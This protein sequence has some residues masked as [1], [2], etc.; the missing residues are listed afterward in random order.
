MTNQIEDFDRAIPNPLALKLRHY[1]HRFDVFG[2]ASVHLTNGDLHRLYWVHKGP[3]NHI[4]SRW[5][6]TSAMIAR[7]PGSFRNATIRL[8]RS[9]CAM[10]PKS[11]SGDFVRGD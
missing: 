8:P 6:K 9:Y 3:S 4:A 1:A 7:F 5:P 10:P 11:Q 2:K